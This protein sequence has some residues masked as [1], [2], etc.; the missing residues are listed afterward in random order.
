MERRGEMEGVPCAKTCGEVIVN[1]QVWR[2]GGEG[3][4][5]EGR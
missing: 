1:M 4:G 2:R 3:G 5:G